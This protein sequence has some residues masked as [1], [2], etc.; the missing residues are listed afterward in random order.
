MSL[1]ARPTSRV[2]GS[3]SRPRAARTVGAPAVAPPL[4]SSIATLRR[5]ESNDGVWILYEQQKWI[6]AGRPIPFEDSEF[7]RIGQYGAFPVFRRAGAAEELIYV[8]ARAGQVMP[9]RLK[10]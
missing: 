2:V 7:E 1:P 3:P 6:G 5:P 9:Y 4:A 10:P 8:P